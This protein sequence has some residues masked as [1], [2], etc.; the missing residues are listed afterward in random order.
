MR[1]KKVTRLRLPDRRFDGAR[2]AGH[3]AGNRIQ[4]DPGVTGHK[5]AP[6]MLG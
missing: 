2:V 3:K 1:F 6:I 4:I 5:S